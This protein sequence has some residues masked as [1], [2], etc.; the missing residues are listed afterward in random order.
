MKTKIGLV[1]LCASILSGCGT[2]T[3]TKQTESDR[4]ASI[5]MVAAFM[6]SSYYLLDHPQEYGAFVLARNGLDALSKSDEATPIS[7]R[8]VLSAL[9][10]DELNGDRTSI[11]ITAT[12]ILIFDGA[13]MTAPELPKEV[14]RVAGSIRD[15][16]D[17]AIGMVSPSGGLNDK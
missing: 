2:I 7:L 10:M 6:G 9:P 13:T 16:L 11:L 1:C 14:R 8:E 15:G 17:L 12:S 4:I 3:F 5:A